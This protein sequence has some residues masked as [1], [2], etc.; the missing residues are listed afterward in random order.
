MFIKK[1]TP[2]FY[3][4]LLKDVKGLK[5][6]VEAYLGVKAKSKFLRSLHSKAVL[7]TYSETVGYPLLQR[8][9]T[10]IEEF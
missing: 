3:E 1:S 9:S 4:N 10:Y 8:L 5:R 7:I 2:S 6:R